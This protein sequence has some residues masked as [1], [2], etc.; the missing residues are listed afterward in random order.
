MAYR[1][2][3]K[4]PAVKA[5][6]AVPNPDRRRI[7]AAIESLSH[8]PR[9][10]GCMKLH[11]SEAAYRIRVGDYRIVYEIADSVLVVWVIR[12]AHRKDVYR[13]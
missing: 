1:I 3:I 6:S 12:I 13:R 7:A 10:S 11:G 2:E 5:L 8:T 9:P 4:L